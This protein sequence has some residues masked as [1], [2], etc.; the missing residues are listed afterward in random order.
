MR[1]VASHQSTRQAAHKSTPRANAP[2]HEVHCHR[3]RVNKPARVP[4]RPTNHAHSRRATLHARLHSRIHNGPTHL[5][6]NARC[7]LVPVTRQASRIRR[8]LRPLSMMLIE[9]TCQSQR[10]NKYSNCLSNV[11]IADPSPLT[12][13]IKQ[14]R[15]HMPVHQP[16]M[17]SFDTGQSIC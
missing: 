4:K 11:L 16:I 2:V 12:R 3:V 9:A 6:A 15:T 14:P 7:H 17:H 8:R 10:Q 5:S 1:N 13:H